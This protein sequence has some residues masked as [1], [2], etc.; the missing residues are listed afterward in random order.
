MADL[1]LKATGEE[2]DLVVGNRSE[3]SVWVDGDLAAAKS[4]EGFPSEEVLLAD[5]RRRLA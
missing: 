5:V 4:L 3:L 1:I 2:V